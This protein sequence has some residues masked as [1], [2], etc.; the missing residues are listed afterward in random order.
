VEND[1]ILELN[2]E[3]I[4]ENHSLARMLAQYAPGD[5]VELKVWRKGDEKTVKVKL[6]E[7]KE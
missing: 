3:K 5:E 6:A 2:G 1:L 4:D 7:R